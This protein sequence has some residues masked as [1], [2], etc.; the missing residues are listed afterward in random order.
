[1]VVKCNSFGL[2]GIDSYKVEVEATVAMGMPAFDIVG[3]PDTAV[4]ESRDRVRSAMKNCGFTFP[5][6]RITVNLA[7]ADIRKE[8]PIY[9]LPIL[10]AILKSTGQFNSNISDCAFI[11][12]LS[13]GG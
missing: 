5:S 10:I 7:P 13:L 6:A 9:D 11:G 3:L 2:F 4:K 8:G 12:E 1:M